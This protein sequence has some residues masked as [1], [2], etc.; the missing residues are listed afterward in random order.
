M[1]ALGA[2]AVAVE[3]LKL[4]GWTW[5]DNL[6]AALDLDSVEIPTNPVGFIGTLIAVGVTFWG[7][8]VA[9]ALVHARPLSSLVA[10]AQPFRWSIVGKVAALSV[11]LALLSAAGEFL[12]FPMDTLV[13]VEGIGKEQL[14][15]FLPALAATLVQ[16][17]GEDAYF[18]GL[19]LHRLGAV[20]RIA[21]IAPVIVTCGFVALHIG[22]PDVASDLW[23]MLPLFV[24]SE[25]VI[26]YLILRTG[27]IEA[28]FALHW[29]NN[30]VVFLLVA[31]RGTQANDLTVVTYENP[32]TESVLSGE[33][34]R[35]LAAYLV[36]L[37][38]LV[39]ALVWRRSPFWLMPYET[40]VLN[41]PP[42]PPNEP[43]PPQNEPPPPQNPEIATPFRRASFEE[44]V[45]S[46]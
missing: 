2:F 30:V 25:L 1:I 41:E 12:L 42:P 15:W 17:S 19:L 37:T 46:R 36:F 5:A 44:W 20:V 33:L 6:G 4:T 23:I 21:W 40:P 24:L 26:M 35:G 14:G 38:L 18:K 29:V 32:V 28:A 39:A 11:V 34:L 31:D 27:G 22:N 7:A 10:P 3:L 16:T 13:T 8:A 45:E 43:P 9:G